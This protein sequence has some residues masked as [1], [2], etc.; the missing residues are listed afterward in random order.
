MSD[1]FYI[2]NLILSLLQLKSYGY[3]YCEIHLLD[4]FKENF[5]GEDVDFPAAVSFSAVSDG[6]MCLVDFP[7]VPAVPAEEIQKFAFEFHS[8]PRRFVPNF[9]S[10]GGSK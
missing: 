9:D 4:A 5:D 7:S 6:G 1:N 8:T 2:D 10:E 3:S